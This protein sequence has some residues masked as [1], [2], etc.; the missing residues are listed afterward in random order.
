MQ[1]PEGSAH[2]GW[3]ETVLVLKAKARIP[4][5]Q[6]E[7]SAIIGRMTERCDCLTELMEKQRNYGFENALRILTVA[8]WKVSLVVEY[9]W[10]EVLR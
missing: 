3:P 5:M 1:G 8:S 2:P 7:L 4:G 10:S 6:T 9:D